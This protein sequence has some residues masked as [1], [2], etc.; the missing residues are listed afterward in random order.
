MKSYIVEQGKI[1]FRQSSL[2]VLF[3]VVLAQLGVYI[4]LTGSKRYPYSVAITESEF[5]SAIELA[6]D[7]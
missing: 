1:H 4:H 5:L 6:T 3:F 2:P 7:S